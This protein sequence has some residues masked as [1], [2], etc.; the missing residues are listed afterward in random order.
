[1]RNNFHNA[2]LE[3]LGAAD[4]ISLDVAIIY[5]HQPAE[6]RTD[7]SPGWNQDVDL[8][9][10]I[11]Q[12]FRSA[13]IDVDLTVRRDWGRAADAIAYEYVSEEWEYF[14][15]EILEHELGYAESAIESEY[16]ARAERLRE[17]EGI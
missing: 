4:S 12:R 5:R 14:S 8:E 3:E 15:Q 13:G 2:T 17:R 1:M 11:V 16:E 7:V 6:R 10:V 9:G